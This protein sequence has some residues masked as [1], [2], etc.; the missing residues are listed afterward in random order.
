MLDAYLDKRLGE[1][2][3]Y[4]STSDK[5][6]KSLDSLQVEFAPTA[7]DLVTDFLFS[8]TRFGID[9]ARVAGDSARVYVTSRS[10]PFE[11]VLQQAQIVERDLGPETDM[12]TKLSV[13][14]ERHRL[15]GGPI[16]ENQTL[17]RLIREDG[18]WRVDVGW[19]AMAA[20]LDASIEEG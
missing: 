16:E 10:P 2:Y 4:V 11:F 13:L 5:E 20:Y 7:A 8:A 6:I 3:Q 9:S 17:Y 14:N 12:P 19:A 1:Y 15:S 18:G